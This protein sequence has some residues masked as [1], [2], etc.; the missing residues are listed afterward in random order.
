MVYT[1]IIQRCKGYIIWH[2]GQRVEMCYIFSESTGPTAW[3]KGGCTWILEIM[4]SSHFT[5]HLFFGL[6]IQFL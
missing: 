4:D 3:S 1:K 6:I 2:G 5:F